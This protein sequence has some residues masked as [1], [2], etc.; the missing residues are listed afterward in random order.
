MIL[1]NSNQLQ[2]YNSSFFGQRHNEFYIWKVFPFWGLGA[3]LNTLLI[4]SRLFKIFSPENPGLINGA[5]FILVI[6]SRCLAVLI[7]VNDFPRQP[8]T[9][10]VE[11]VTLELFS[12]TSTFVRLTSFWMLKIGFWNE[13]NWLL[14][15]LTSGLS[16]HGWLFFF[17]F[18]HF[19]IK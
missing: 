18:F 4:F 1:S 13:R 17:W 14:A 9:K 5:P 16:F 3:S 19:G 12:Q 7:L 10:N 2:M 6:L 8:V 15:P 11:V